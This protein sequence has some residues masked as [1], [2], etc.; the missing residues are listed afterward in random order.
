MGLSPWCYGFLKFIN[1]SFACIYLK[2]PFFISPVVNS[3][4]CTY[5]CVHY[6]SVLHLMV[7]LL[8]EFLFQLVYIV[9]SL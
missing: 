8:P 4:V 9:F 7:G 2:S 5:V 6:G 1:N 3:H